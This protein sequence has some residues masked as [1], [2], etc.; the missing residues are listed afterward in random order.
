MHEMIKQ[1][2]KDKHREIKRRHMRK[3]QKRNVVIKY[4]RNNDVKFRTT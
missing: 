1:Y 4:G 2:K 3:A